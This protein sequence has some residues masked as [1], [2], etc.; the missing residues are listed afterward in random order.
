MV[1]DLAR[2]NDVPYAEADRMARMIPDELN[3]SLEESVAK[4]GELRT[5][6]ND[7]PLARSIVEQGQVIEGMVR[8]TGKHACG[9][10]IAD[11]SIGNL[12]PVTL[13]E[14]DLTTQ[15]PK[16]PV[17]DPR[18]AENGFP[19]IENPDSHIGR[20]G[21]CPPVKEPAGFRY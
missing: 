6:L 18:P 20:A 4:S 7:N 8:N 15:F 12:V 2:V 1:R 13:Q 5:E 19:G 17:E 21:K 11:Q 10:I 9:V 16:G 14:G 3:I